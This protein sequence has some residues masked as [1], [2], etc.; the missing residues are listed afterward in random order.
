MNHSLEPHFHFYFSNFI[1]TILKNLTRIKSAAPSIPNGG[2]EFAKLQVFQLKISPRFG[3]LDGHLHLDG[4]MRVVV[5]ELKVIGCELVNV[6]DRPLDPELGERPWL[7]SQLLLQGLHVVQIDVRVANGVHKL[8]R[9]GARHMSDHV[10]EQG[11][12]GDVERNAEALF[13]VRGVS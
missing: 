10:G 3:K 2:C 13:K 12:G 6:L 5:D 9:L 7:A 11:V 8:A 1:Y 4:R